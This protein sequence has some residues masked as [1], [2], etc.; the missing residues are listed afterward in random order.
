MH[1]DE[2]VFNEGLDVG[3]RCYVF[4][5]SAV[6][7]IVSCIKAAVS[8]QHYISPAVSTHLLSAGA[9]APLRSPDRSRVSAS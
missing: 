6:M 2:D 3:A 9:R 1:K 8:G 5:D 7:E 4:K